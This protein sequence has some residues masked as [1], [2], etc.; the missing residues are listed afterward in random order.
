MASALNAAHNFRS[1][2]SYTVPTAFSG[3]AFSEKIAFS[4]HV[5]ARLKNPLNA[6]TEVFG[7]I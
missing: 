3:N 1:T 2:L 4:G 6:V 7:K 5:F